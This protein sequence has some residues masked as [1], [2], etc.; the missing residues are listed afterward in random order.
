MLGNLYMQTNFFETGSYVATLTVLELLWRQGWP[1]TRRDPPASATLV[2]G[3][4]VCIITPG[5]LCVLNAFHLTVFSVYGELIG[6]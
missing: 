6:V 2:L 3:L 5:N 1:Q 4:K